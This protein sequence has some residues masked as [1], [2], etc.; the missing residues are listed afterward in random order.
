MAVEM[1][2]EGSFA[3]DVPAYIEDNV[4]AKVVKIIQS[5]TAII[6]KIIW[7]KQI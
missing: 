6:N 1:N 2:K 5:Y 3:S 7:R 4:S